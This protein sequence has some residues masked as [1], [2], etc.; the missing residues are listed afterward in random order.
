VPG[1]PRFIPYDPPRLSEE[2]MLRRARDLFREMDGRRSVRDFSPDPVPRELIE[3]AIRCASTSPSGAHRQ[4]WKFVVV[5]DP[6]VKRRIRAAAEAEERLSYEGGRMP[7]DWLEALRPLGTGWRKPYLETAPWIV[8]VFE[9]VYGAGPDGARRKNYY[10]KES[11]GMACGLF[12]A[13]VHRMGLA[14][15][16]H[17]PSPMKFLSEI[18]GRA[19]NERPYVLFP[20]GYPARGAEVPDI[21]RKGLDEISVWDPDRLS[22]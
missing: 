17:T 14:T 5:S 1:E 10:V 3:T 2:E 9:E 12:I 4:P 7:D 6:A 18:L 21:R 22:R 16:T 19:E 15:L 13:A 20:V 8:V 11:V